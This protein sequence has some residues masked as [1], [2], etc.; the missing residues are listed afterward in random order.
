MDLRPANFL[1]RR[2]RLLGLIDWSNA[3]TANALLELARVEEYGGLTDRFAL[4]YGS[5]E[6][7][8]ELQ[9]PLGLCCRLYTAAMLAIVFLSE[10]P[11]R[12]LATIKVKR[13]RDLLEQLRAVS[14]DG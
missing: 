4:G 2:G 9:R 7:Q 8:A 1:S 3:L 13:L 10:A 6:L 11:D 5:T 14:D 12:S